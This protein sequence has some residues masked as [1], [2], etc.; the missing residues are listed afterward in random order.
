M[1]LGNRGIVSCGEFEP[2]RVGASNK[3]VETVHADAVDATSITL[4]GQ[5]LT[6]TLNTLASQTVTW[7]SI[8]GVPSYLVDW[9]TDQ[10][11]DVIHPDNYQNTE[12]GLASN[13]GAGLSRYNFNAN[14]KNKLN[15]IQNNA[16][17][18]VKPDWNA[19]AGS[20]A[21]ILNQPAWLS[22][23]DPGYLTAVPTSVTD[24][25]ALNSA[26]TS[27]P[28]PPS[29][30]QVTSKPSWIPV[31]DPGYL[32]AV[33]T[34]VIDE[35]AL[36]STKIGIT[37]AQATAI[38][39]NS[40][41]VSYPGPPSWSQ[42]TSKP[43]LQIPLTIAINANSTFG[44]QTYVNGGLHLA[45]DGTLTYIPQSLA[46]L[47]PINNASFTGTVNLPTNTIYGGHA[48]ST[49]FAGF[50]SAATVA[51]NTAKCASL[52]TLKADLASPTFTGTVSLPGTT[53]VSGVNLS[54]T[55]ANKANLTT[56]AVFSWLCQCRSGRER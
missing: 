32:T 49:T 47:A 29:W 22:Q 37:S 20:D 50:G 2:K 45:S 44:G 16:E 12:Y 24:A 39:T 9:T 15:G 54:T 10:G 30:S 3:R 34:S 33:P 28:G 1:N 13:A 5:D 6:T 7:G 21:E 51:L 56:N 46:G 4:N 36:N 53:L 25:I 18:N 14:R 43:A 26:K 55:L 35:I 23:S 8:S 17:R 38:Q 19:T 31:S 41:K 48:L 52:D 42:V 27:Y 40:T 11:D